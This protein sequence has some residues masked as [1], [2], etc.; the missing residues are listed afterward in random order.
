MTLTVTDDGGLTSSVTHQLSVVKPNVPPSADFSTTCAFLVCD[1]DASTS[2]DGDGTI[3]A[4]AWDFGDGETGAGSAPNHV[5]ETPGNY[6]VSLVVTDD[7][8]ATDDISSEQV[9]VGEPAPSTVSYVGGAVNQGNVSTPN[10][11]TPTSVSAGDRVVMV[12][13]VNASNRV[14][15]APTGVTGW[16]V[17]GT[18]TSGTVQ[19][20][21]W[22]KIATAADASKKITVAMDAAAKYTMTVADYSGVRPGVLVH[23]DLAETVTRA[24][25]ATPIVDAPAGS[26][27]VSYWADKSSATTGFALPGPVTGRHAL[28]GTSSGHICSSLADSDGGVPTGQY[29][30]L[31]ATADTASAS[32]TAWS[33]IL[34]T[35]EPNQAPIA[36]FTHTCDGAECDFEGAVSSDPDGSVVSYAWDFGDGGSA[37]GSTASHDFMTSGTRDVTLTVTDDEGTQGSLVVPISVVRS[38]AAPTASFTATCAFLACSFDPSASGDSDGN[39]TSYAWD[40]GDGE[41]TTGVSP[42]HSYDAA[43]PYVVTLTVTDNDDATGSTTRD[44]SPVAVRPIAL[45]GSSANQ[46]NVSTPNATVPVG[47][48]AGDRLLMVLSLNDS[49]RV[50][51]TTTGVTGWALLDTATS[52]TLQTNVYTKVAAAADA[53]KTVRFAM[54][55]AA[56]YTLTVAAY[57]GDQ[58]VPELAKAS[59]T[60]VRAGH[61]TPTLE[62][63]AGDWAVS[64]W[65]DK[66][67]ATTGFTL[68]GGVTQR[69]ALCN[70]NAGRICSVLA[71]SDGGVSAGTYGALSATSNAASGSAT[72]WTV[73]L[74]QAS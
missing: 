68:P 18:T 28:C 13:S 66:S 31:L 24:D 52:G 42:T 72:M 38:N 71:D 50:V 10:V 34:R 43:G 2:A 58:L 70:A 21:V 35:V 25:H 54:D 59:E 9:V 30:G 26:W 14:L 11:T 39:P 1:F 46:G 60:A 3:D 56:K 8:G 55:A 7:D 49:T 5:Y 48:S 36:S 45:V 44:I 33:I 69:Q 16:T 62:A 23:A 12:L 32:A 57:T 47:T 61:T 65:A 6:T 63:G 64:Y 19:T 41:T 67:S 74:R 20:R 27:V 17:L 4:Y 15:S 22:T 53:G 37:T 51:G 40:F 73:L 29:G